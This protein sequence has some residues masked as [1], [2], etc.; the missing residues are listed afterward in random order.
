[1]EKRMNHAAFIYCGG[2]LS[3][4]LLAE[5]LHKWRRRNGVWLRLQLQKESVGMYAFAYVCLPVN[6]RSSVCKYSMHRWHLLHREKLALFWFCWVMA[7]KIGVKMRNFPWRFLGNHVFLAILGLLPCVN[8][9]N[10]LKNQKLF[11]N[12][13]IIW[14]SSKFQGP[15]S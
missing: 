9:Q 12:K 2:W 1:M 8:M 5:A 10:C 11:D 13:K 7:A 4:I 6:L 15:R 3:G 14:I